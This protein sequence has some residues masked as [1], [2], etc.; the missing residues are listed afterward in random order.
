MNFKKSI[1]AILFLFAVL[2][3][4]VAFSQSNYSNVK[5][6][7]LSDAQIREM[8]SRAE[9]IGYNDAQ[10]EQMAKA[11]GMKAEEVEKLRARVAKIRSGKEDQAASKA[12]ETDK[13]RQFEGGTQGRRDS[14]TTK[15]DL[16]ESLRPKIF[17]AELFA[18][19]N[20]SF[21]PNFRMAT[22]RNY[23]IGP[24]DELLIDLSGDNEADYKLKVNPEGI[25]RLQY[26]GP[27]SVGG[28]TIEQAIAKIRTKLAGTYPGLRTG[29]TSVAVNLGNIRSIKI[30]LLG[31]VVKPGS[32]TLSSLST[33]FNAL[34]ASG[35]PNMNG[36]F[37]KIQ[38]IRG[39]KIVATVDVYD[40]LLNGIQKTNIRLQDQDVINIP[41][42]QS[43]VE[44]SGE[45][46]RPAL[47][48]VLSNES[49]ADVIRFAG[50]FSNEAYTAQIKVL[51]NTNKERRITDVT[52]EKFDTYG[53]LNGDKYIVEG[54]LDRF[55]NRVE[56]AGA[57]FRPGKFELDKGLTLKGLIAKAD[58]LK[59]DAFLNRG[60]IN[61]LNADNTLALISFDVAKVLAGTDQ[62]IALQREDRVTISSLFDLRDE[63]KLSIQGEVRAPGDFDYADNMTLADMIQ[64]AGGFKEGATPNRIEI[65]R[66]VRNSDSLSKSAI[67]AELFT[68]NIDKNLRLEGDPFILKPYDI[69]TVRNSAGY[70]IQKQVK[71]E[72]EV[73]YPGVYTISSKDERISDLIKRAGGLTPIAYA[74]GASLKR[75]G[76]EKVN[77][78]DKNAIDNKEEENKKFLSLKRAQEAG[79]KDTLHADVEQKLIQSD[80]VGI[81]L[82]RILHKPHSRY[83]LIVEDGDLIRVPRQLQTVK[84]TGEVLNPNSIVYLPGKSFKQYV[85]GAGGFTTSALKKG[86]YIKYANGSVE[87]GSK[88]LFFN[89]FPKVRPGAEILVPKRAERERMSAQGWIG[90]GTA[91]ASLGAIIVSLLR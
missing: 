79:V 8:I 25:I 24:D 1:T 27:V 64:L 60:Y 63:Y 34:N 87:A 40:F 65:S 5:V 56:I 86:A 82:E 31:E 53:P 11:Q 48:E 26:T 51:Q 89:N 4:Q 58:G 76:A 38:V 14:T 66:R 39:N 28:L 68:I 42:Y 59:E 44:M 12:Q 61:R 72:G 83:D 17:G 46:K 18:N 2:I 35:G 81:S 41:V 85:N 7:E 50:G 62:D 9:S 54:I 80:L 19:S 74:E 91:L 29:R 90:L 37:R 30:T 32:Y 15:V 57:V 16:F 88:F 13:G 10:L 20:I 77:P 36:S 84:V 6:D 22:P 23:V 49:L 78:D 73:L 55:E 21:E 67:T 47:F 3:T 71:L 69:V 75:P 45:V 70:A 33:V 43:R 52:A